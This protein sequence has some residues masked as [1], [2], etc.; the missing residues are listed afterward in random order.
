VDVRVDALESADPVADDLAVDDPAED[1]PAV[2]EVEGTRAV[3][4]AIANA[5]QRPQRSCAGAASQT[6]RQFPPP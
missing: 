5:N 4:E 2:I 6:Q 1:I 3:A